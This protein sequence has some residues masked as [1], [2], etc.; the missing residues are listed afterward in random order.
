MNKITL[1]LGIIVSALVLAS[2]TT[3][4]GAIEQPPAPHATAH[5]YKGEVK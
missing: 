5:D 2:C 1:L 4:Q 3:N